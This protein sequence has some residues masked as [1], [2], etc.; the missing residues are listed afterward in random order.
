MIMKTVI[1]GLLAASIILAGIS[2]AMAFHGHD[3]VTPYG[4]FCTRVSHYGMHKGTIPLEQAEE[5]LKHYYSE[6]GLEIEIIQEEERF[7][8][9]LVKD[10][11]TVV[12]T[13]IFDRR[14]GRLRSIY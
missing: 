7:L 9:A 4:D 8:K 6:K 2:P 12:D 5:A 10:G 13:V 11:D 3:R 14:T 1:T